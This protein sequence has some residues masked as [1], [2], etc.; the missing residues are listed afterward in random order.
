MDICGEGRAPSR[1]HLI[2]WAKE[3]E[4]E[5]KYAVD[6]ITAVSAIAENFEKA[7]KA[8]A[9]RRATIKSIDSLIQDNLARMKP[10]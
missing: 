9:I 7:A 8:F 1:T 10:R 3:A 2:R 6:I 5:K 4:V